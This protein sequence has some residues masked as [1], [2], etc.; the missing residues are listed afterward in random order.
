MWELFPLSA[1]D[2]C[3]FFG[4]VDGEEEV[5]GG[6]ESPELGLARRIAEPPAAV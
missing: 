5:E 3:G 6:A 2:G 1:S 4:P